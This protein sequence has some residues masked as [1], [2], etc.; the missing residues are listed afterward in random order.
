M[1]FVLFW[2]FWGWLILVGFVLFCWF[3]PGSV[4]YTSHAAFF[5]VKSVF[6]IQMPKASR[7]SV[8]GCKD[9]PVAAQP[10]ASGLPMRFT[11]YCCYWLCW[12]T[13]L[14]DARCKPGQVSCSPSAVY[15]Q[16]TREECSCQFCVREV[17]EITFILKAYN[18]LKSATTWIL[19]TSYIWI[20][21]QSVCYI[22][23]LPSPVVVGRWDKKTNTCASFS[24]LSFAV[25]CFSLFFQMSAV[26]FQQLNC[27]GKCNF[28]PD[29][30]NSGARSYLSNLLSWTLLF[31]TFSLNMYSFLTREKY[32]IH[33]HTPTQ[34]H[35]LK[36]KVFIAC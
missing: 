22:C 20:L 18:M 19:W 16:I 15:S 11:I 28:K 14:Q 4:H 8:Q 6:P 9:P 35:T 17:C 24:G 13:N 5:H 36:T 23:T 2:G 30:Y 34:I 1:G 31:R 25:F 3:F 32:Q 10:K 12:K 27:S 21:N 29:H 26:L 33:I 7:T